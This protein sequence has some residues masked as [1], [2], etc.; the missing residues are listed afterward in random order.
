MQ[1]LFDRP[2]SVLRCRA[3]PPSPLIK[4]LTPLE[5]SEEKGQSFSASSA[6]CLLERAAGYTS[7]LTEILKRENIMYSAA[8]KMRGSK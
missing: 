2:T 4:L 7:D 3:G 5:K 6:A 8:E 1:T